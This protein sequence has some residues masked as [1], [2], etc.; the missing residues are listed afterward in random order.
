MKVIREG[1]NVRF[2]YHYGYEYIRR[3]ISM[4]DL[5]FFLLSGLQE[6]N[7]GAGKEPEPFRAF[8]LTKYLPR[9]ARPNLRDNSFEREQDSTVA[10]IKFFGDKP[11]HEIDL[12]S[13]EKYK[14]GRLKGSLPF[15]RKPCVNSTVDKE[16]DCLKR[17]L[18]YAASLKLV[19]M[20]V[21]ASVKGLKVGSR[22]AIWLRLKQIDCLLRHC[23]PWLANLLEFRILTGARPSEAL[24]FG[25]DNIDLQKGEIWLRTLK[26]RDGKEHRRYIP[27]DSLGLRFKALL[28]RMAPHP[29]TGYFFFKRAGRPYSLSQVEHL[30]AKARKLS[31]L[32]H[33]I[34]YD[35]RGTF[36]MH[37]AMVVKNFRQ[38]QTE[39]GHGNPQS[40]QSY[41]DE[42][43]RF[44]VEESIFH[45]PGK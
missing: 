32:E 29:E 33:V 5:S 8:V 22:R 30:F 16:F 39:M 38:L 27:I 24:E 36:A 18:G 10:L 17:I 1:E 13:W 35:L 41:L 4:K 20:N 15:C 14:T 31:G 12:E 9:C 26:K 7:L 25:R 21:L 2:D 23:E 42:A 11:V 28:G 45:V 3:V 19:K 6:S 34:S 40:I 44:R 37:R 43:S